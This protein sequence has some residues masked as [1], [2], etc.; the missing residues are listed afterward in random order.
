[1][2]AMCS[3]RAHGTEVVDDG[4]AAKAPAAPRNHGRRVVDAQ[5]SNDESC[6]TIDVVHC[7][8]VELARWLSQRSTCISN[9]HVAETHKLDFACRRRRR[10]RAACDTIVVL[11]REE[12]DRPPL[13][14]WDALLLLYSPRLQSIARLG[15]SNEQRI[16]LACAQARAEQSKHFRRIMMKRCRHQAKCTIN[17]KKLTMFLIV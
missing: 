10:R 5:T 3:A 2:S 4:A 6:G 1:M 11:C 8:R 14:V 15:G 17:S 9:S 7:C 12:T 16:W 13:V